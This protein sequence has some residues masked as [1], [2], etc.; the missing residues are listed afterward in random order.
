[1]TDTIFEQLKEE[2]A[3]GKALPTPQVP[4]NLNRELL[5]F[6]LRPMTDE[7]ASTASGVKMRF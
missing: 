4:G 2:I 3:K 7:E 1:M 5:P 6:I